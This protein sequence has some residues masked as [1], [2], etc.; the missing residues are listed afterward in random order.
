MGKGGK[1]RQLLTMRTL[2]RTLVIALILIVGATLLVV[3]NHASAVNPAATLQGKDMGAAPAPAFRLT[4]QT[5]QVISLAELRGHPVVVTFLFTHCPDVCPL[6]AE[7]LAAGASALGA[8][9]DQVKWVAISVDPAGDTPASTTAFTSAHH[10]TG[11]LHFLLGT[12]DQ[13]APIW[14]GY[15]I[16]VQAELN[17]QTGQQTVMHG[18]GV[19]VL[20]GQG[21]ERVY[22]SDQFD[23]ATLAHDLRVV[24]AE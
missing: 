19:F 10:L 6:T 8:R 1:V 18:I 9:A 12:A 5:G 24:L 14:Q 4:D 22:L 20:D 13:L 7:K 2:S 3:R 21:R 15:F 23:P 17:A 16:A 11:R